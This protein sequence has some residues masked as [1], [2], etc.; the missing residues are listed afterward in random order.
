M[1]RLL[2]IG[3]GGHGRVAADIAKRI[4]YQ[5][6]AFLDDEPREGVIASTSQFI[7]F[8]DDSDFFVAIG[9]SSTRESIQRNL[10][11]ANASVV[12][13]IHPSAIIAD[14][15][16]IGQG[17]L[18]SAGAIICVDAVIGD[19]TIVNTSASVDHDCVIENFVHIAVGAHVCGTVNIGSRTWVGA[20]AT[21]NNN[22][23]IVGDCMIGVG[24]VVVSSITESGT[25][26]GVPAR[27]RS[28]SKTV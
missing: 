9:N 28:C 18:V 4:G 15:V 12:T 11:N 22:V 5:E 8:I 25:Y 2:I 7:Q 1:K 16:K 20:G 17:C 10:M 13:L 23:N 21:V 26:T 3:A 24:A 27:K 6:I 19:G 14:G